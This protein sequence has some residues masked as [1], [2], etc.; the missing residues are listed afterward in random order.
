MRTIHLLALILLAAC[1]GSPTQ[2]RAEILT[3]DRALALVDTVAALVA[4]HYHDVGFIADRWPSI[5]D[6]YRARVRSMRTPSGAPA[7]IDA[8]MQEPGDSHFGFGHVDDIARASSPYLFAQG[9]VGLDLRLHDTRAIV[10]HVE[11]G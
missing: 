1:S 7:L 10:T 2:S 5:V 6:R 4:T 11:S 3:N 9:S 8:M